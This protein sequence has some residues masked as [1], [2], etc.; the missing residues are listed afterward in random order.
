MNQDPANYAI[1]AQKAS[2]QNKLLLLRVEEYEALFARLEREGRPQAGRVSS[3]ICEQLLE[4]LFCLR[5]L[6]EFYSQRLLEK[7]LADSLSEMD[8]AKAKRRRRS[9]RIDRRYYPRR[10]G[11]TGGRNA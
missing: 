5:E 7:A 2:A 1:D 9:A 6:G 8:Q 3:A 4:M 10:Q 11:G